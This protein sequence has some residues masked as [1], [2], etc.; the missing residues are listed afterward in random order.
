[1]HAIS[2]TYIDLG[3]ASFLVVLLAA[4]SFRFRLGLTKQIV[5]A[6]IRTFVQLAMVG[7]ILRFVFAQAGIGWV[8]VASTGMLLMGGKEIRER[9]KNRLK[10][11]WDFGVGT[12][13][14]FLSSFLLATFTLRF[15]IEVEPFYAAR[16]SLPI[17][18]MLLGNTMTGIAL[19]LNYLTDA[20]LQQR[21]TIEQRLLLGQSK[22]R[23]M[24][25]IRRD[26]IKIG[27]I[28]SINAMA[29]AGIVNLPGM[30]TGQ[31]LAGS[32]PVEAVKYQIL[33][34]L[35]ISSGTGFG[36]MLAIGYT[37]RRFFDARHRLRIDDL[38]DD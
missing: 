35:L 32:P 36:V 21:A 17:L 7:Y 13:A 1:M 2:L 16:Y 15:I 18:G 38:C 37:S 4:L 34:M 8:L 10:G 26:S 25:Q 5:I 29:T 6:A 24:D 22:T 31:I 27:M 9:Q 28:P 33:I 14:M 30:M 12:S 3:F 19:S 23:V 11:W 20:T